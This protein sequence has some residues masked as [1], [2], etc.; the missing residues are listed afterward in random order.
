[1]RDTIRLSIRRRRAGGAPFNGLSTQDQ[2]AW[3][4][5]NCE[6]AF[7][8]AW[9]IAADGLTRTRAQRKD[10]TWLQPGY[11]SD[12]LVVFPAAGD[13]CV[14]DEAAPPEQSVNGTDTGRQLLTVVTAEG[15]T[16]TS[17]VPLTAADPLPYLRAELQAAARQFMPGNVMQR[18]VDELN[19]LRL[20]AFMA[21]HPD[22]RGGPSNNQRQVT[23]A[24]PPSIGSNGQ[25]P[26]PYDPT[27]I[28]WTLTL[29]QVDDWWLNS[30][31]GGHPFHIHVNPFQIYKIERRTNA[32]NRDLTNDPSSEYYGMEG[33]WKDTIFVQ[34][35][36]A[37]VFRTKYQRYIGDFVLHCHILDH[38]DAGMMQNVR[39][40]LPDGQGGQAPATHESMRH[41]TGAGVNPQLQPQQPDQEP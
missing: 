15:P 10:N 36:A 11:R 8:P 2:Q 35:D 16:P 5:T 38:E 29:N 6:P 31:G 18:V 34:Q 4:D 26:R 9:E 22:L 30:N 32:P 25:P 20:G 41:T 12:L 13:Y 19:E 21:P 3:I 14:V 37:V 33:V 27:R 40:A 39:I 23:F 28:D 7:L 24:F 1:M 17:P